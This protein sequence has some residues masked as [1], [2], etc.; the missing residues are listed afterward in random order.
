MSLEHIQAI[1]RRLDRNERLGIIIIVGMVALTFF[2][3]GQRWEASTDNLSRAVWAIYALGFT[4]CVLL[5]YRQLHLRRDPTEP[6]A[7]FLRRRL[8]QRLSTMR[9]GFLI[10]LLP[11]APG[12]IGTLALGAFSLGP[13]ASPSMLAGRFLPFAVLMAVWI[14]VMAIM[15]PR[16]IRRF[17]RELDELNAVMK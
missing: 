8:E 6:G 3:T 12:L 13:T 16:Q 10:P 14:A 7:V 4:A 2:V 15:V 9:G 5:M 11:L 17:R 1:N